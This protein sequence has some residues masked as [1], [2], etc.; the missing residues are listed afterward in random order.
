MAVLQA[1]LAR[2]P[3]APD[4]HGGDPGLDPAW[5]PVLLRPGREPV[6]VD[7]GERPPMVEV[8]AYRKSA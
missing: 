4:G 5:S 8:P 1:A 2:R 6:A 3:A 7:G